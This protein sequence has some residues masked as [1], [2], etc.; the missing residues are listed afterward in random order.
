MFHLKRIFKMLTSSGR[1]KP[2]FIIV[3][4]Q[5]CAT[6]SL[7]DYICRHPSVDGAEVK[8]V[9]YF[10]LRYNMGNCWYRS[11]FPLRRKGAITG[12]STPSLVWSTPSF[13]SIKTLLP[14]VKILAVLRDPV[15]RAIS[16]YYH[17]VRQGRETRP[18]AEAMFAPESLRSAKGL[19]PGSNEYL[20]SLRFGYISK[21]R[22]G[23]QLRELDAFFPL[24]ECLVLPFTDVVNIDK[25]TRL[26]VFNFLG[27]Q[28]YEVDLMSRKNV[29]IEKE[30][31][32]VLG[33]IPRIE[34][35]LVE[36]R[37]AVLRMFGWSQF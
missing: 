31:D 5:K 21:S 28:D 8:E 10:D 37:E 34:E 24:E 4:A 18:I 35:Q 11:H 16:H 3:G 7:Y 9:H 20:Q 36:D 13:S 2:A 6:T 1:S 12:E 17:N 19:R 30:K 27:L 26:K 14:S 33:V 32:E 22:Y 29:G 25:K 23:E 15:E